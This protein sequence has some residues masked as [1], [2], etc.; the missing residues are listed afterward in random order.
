M[1]VSF[2][3]KRDDLKNNHALATDCVEADQIDAVA[4]ISAAKDGKAERQKNPW[5][6]GSLPWLS[7]VVARL[8]VWNCYGKPSG[9]KSMADGWHR[10]SL[11]HDVFKLSDSSLP[12]QPKMSGSRSLPGGSGDCLLNDRPM[13]L[14]CRERASSTPSKLRADHPENEVE[15]PPRAGVTA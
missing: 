11:M 7:W 15:I 5:S 10:I 9:P 6:Q 13:A 2:T 14:R 12:W 1:P 3:A 4:T 8:A